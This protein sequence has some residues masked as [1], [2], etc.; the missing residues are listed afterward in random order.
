MRRAGNAGRKEGVAI[1]QS[2]LLEARD[3]VHGTY[4]MPSFGRY[5]VAAEVLDV[6]SD[7]QLAASL[8]R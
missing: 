1:A 7:R 3:L 2:L 4:I 5:E 6:L 8:L